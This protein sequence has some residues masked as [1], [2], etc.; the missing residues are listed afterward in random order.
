MCWLEDPQI[1]EYV[2]VHNLQGRDLEAIFI[3]EVKKL[4]PEGYGRVYWEEAFRLN[5]ALDPETDI[6]QVWADASLLAPAAKAGFRVLRSAG[7]YLDR[8]RPL[9]SVSRYAYAD[10][11]REMCV[12][13]FCFSFG[14]FFFFFLGEIGLITDVFLFFF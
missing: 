13:L 3:R 9:D 14:V 4:F 2:R 6:V 11:W 12:F 8:Q 1:A 10:T 7:L 5:H